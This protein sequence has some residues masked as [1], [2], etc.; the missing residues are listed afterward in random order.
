LSITP[1]N[2]K[3]ATVII[4]NAAATTGTGLLGQYYDTASTTY[5]NSANFNAT[6]LKVTRVDPTVDF[7]WLQGTPNANTALAS[8]D[9]FSVRW[10]GYLAPTTAGSYVFQLDANDKARVFLD[11]DGSGPG[12]LVQ[13]LENGWDTAATGGFKQSSAHTLAVPGT[14]GDRYQIRVE[15]VE[16]TGSATCRFQWNRDGGTFA[17]IPSTNV[18]TNNTGST[19]GW[20]GNYYNDTTFT[21]L[22]VTQTDSAI[23]NGNNGTWGAGTPDPLVHRDT[24][25]VRWTGQVQPQY[26]EEYTFVVNCEDAAKLWIN[27]QPMTLKVATTTNTTGT[28]S[29]N[30]T[31]GDCV[32]THPNIPNGS[33][34]VGESARIEPTSGNLNYA[35]GSDYTYDGATGLTVVDYSNVTTVAP[36]GFLVGETVFLDPTTGNLSSLGSLPYEIIAATSTTFT[37]DFGTGTFTSGT[38]DL[39][40]ADVRDALITAVGTGTITV[41]FGTGKSATGTGNCN[42]DW[43]NKP[44]DWTSASNITADRYARVSL[45]AGVRYDIKLDYFENTGTAKCQLSWYS[46]SQPKQIIPSSRLYPASVPQQQATHTTPA[47]AFAQVGGPFSLAIA[48]SNGATVT[49]T[50]R[51]AWLT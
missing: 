5:S 27:G 33:F 22:A 24:F 16:L 51:P 19:A 17:N 47:E 14:P 20:I 9:N 12:G 10:D 34:V 48:G 40:I 35:G 32:V 44:I 46:P 4:A 21:S 15:F 49:I 50:N 42:I 7:D 45:L 2:P 11:T 6:Q 18:F 36:G 39:N 28:Y 8:A 26:S 25:S 31:T 41:S 13:I 38:G 30:G 43:I 23:T 3:R 1:G 29:Y 37:V